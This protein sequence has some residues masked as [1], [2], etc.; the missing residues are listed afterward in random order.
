MNERLKELAEQCMVVVE[1]VPCTGKDGWTM[2]CKVRQLDSAKFAELI[3]RECAKLAD[4]T[5]SEY[6]M[7]PYKY[8]STFIKEHFGV[9]E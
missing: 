3:V 1:N 8:P 4:N 6:L 9:E 2:L 7:Q 5:P